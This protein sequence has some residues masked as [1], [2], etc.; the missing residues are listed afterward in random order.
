LDRGLPIHLGDA[1]LYLRAGIP[2]IRLSFGDLSQGGEIET[3]VR[4]LDVRAIDPTDGYS[5][6][7][8]RARYL[9]GLA[10]AVLQLL[11]FA[12]LFLATAMAWQADR[13]T[14]DELKPELFAFLAVVI[15]GLDGYAVAYSL[16]VARLLPRYE[17]FPA[18]PGDPFLLQPA[19][20]V[21]LAVYG[22]VA[23]FCW[24]TFRRGGWGRVADRLNIPYRRTTLLLIFSATVFFAW[25][26]NG[27]ATSL[28]LGLPAYLWL[29]IEPRRTLPGKLINTG[30]ALAGLVPVLAGLTFVFRGSEF[31]PTWWFLTLGAAYGLIPLSAVIGFL[32]GAALL[33]RFLRHGLRD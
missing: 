14:T 8:N 13:P 12:P 11:L 19:W 6:R 23:L 27:Y 20:W 22:A 28:F 24:Y 5:L 3:L 7:L 33:V 25:Q 17:L 31:G 32:V 18:T 4:R 30:L 16:V 26:L 10:V 29:W 9:P 2:A 1:A 15:A 21:A